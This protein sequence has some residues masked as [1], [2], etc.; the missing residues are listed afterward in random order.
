[1]GRPE[2]AP[3]IIKF[4]MKM[5]QLNTFIFLNDIGHSNPKARVYLSEYLTKTNAELFFKAWQLKQRNQMTQ[6]FTSNGMC[7]YESPKM[8]PESK[9]IR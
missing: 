5:V 7:T 3:I 8:G 4:A 6:A 1:M 9:L 2:P